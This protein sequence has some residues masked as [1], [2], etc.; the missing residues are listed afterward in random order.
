MSKLT[1]KLS[2]SELASRQCKKEPKECITYDVVHLMLK[3]LTQG[4]NDDLVFTSKGLQKNKH[5]IVRS[6]L[7]QVCLILL[8]KTQE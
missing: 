6:D 7:G 2:L 1:E 8:I 3:I 5:C 4:V